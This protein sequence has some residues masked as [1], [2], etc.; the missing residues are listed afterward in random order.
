[1]LLGVE[2]LMRQLFVV[3]QRRQQ[4]GVFDRGRADQHRLAALAAAADIG[5]DR[6]CFSLA[7]RK[8]W[9]LLSVRRIGWLVGM[10]TVSRP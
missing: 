9:S 6:A 7:V 5:D 10:T 2:H 4:L 1:M 8:T 3:E